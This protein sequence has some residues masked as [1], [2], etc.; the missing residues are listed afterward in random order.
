MRGGGKSV[1][2]ERTAGAKAHR[3]GSINAVEKPRQAH[4]PAAQRASVLHKGLKNIR[5]E[6]ECEDAKCPTKRRAHKRVG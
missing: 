4:I 3:A 1:A 5:G 6:D 2:A